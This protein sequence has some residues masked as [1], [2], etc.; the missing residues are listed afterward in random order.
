[1]L[2]KAWCARVKAERCSSVS[3]V[4]NQRCGYNLAIT[5]HAHAAIALYK[6]AERHAR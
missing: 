6:P 5:M 3:G 2:R 1:M 4:M